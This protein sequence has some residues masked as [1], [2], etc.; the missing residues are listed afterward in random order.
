MTFPV[1]MP[2]Y[3]IPAPMDAPALRWGIP[4]TGWIADQFIRSVR[5]HTRQ[6]I[7]AVGSRS[8]AGADA[9]AARQQIATPQGSYRALVDDDSLD[10]IYVATPHNHR[11]THVMMALVAGRNVLVEKPMA[12][13]HAQASEM[14][15]KAQQEGLFLAEA[16]W[17]YFLPKFDV[18]D[19]ILATGA[20]GQIRSVPTDHGEYFTRDRRIVDPGWPV[21]CSTILA[22]IRYRY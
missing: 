15:A 16:L 9:F 7:A 18:L 5:A 13:D 2:T 10:V 17:T 6:E 3:R 20:L 21:G 1:E 8:R 12:L 22:P 11:H 19:Q 4:G 14:A